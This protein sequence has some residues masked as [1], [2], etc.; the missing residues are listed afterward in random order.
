[1]EDKQHFEELATQDEAAKKLGISV[2]TLRKYSLII[3]DATNNRQHYIRTRRNSRLYSERNIVELKT[4]KKL[5][6]ENKLTLQDAA[7]QMFLISEKN[8]PKAGQ[9]ENLTHNGALIDAKQ[10]VNLLNMLQQTIVNQNKAI[11]DL[12]AQITRIEKQ[13]QQ[14]IDSSHQLPSKA[15]VA[16]EKTNEPNNTMQ[17]NGKSKSQSPDQNKSSEE[18]KAAKEAREEI[19]R[20]AR[21]NQQKRA[22]QNVHR[23]LAE[24]QIRQ[25]RH[26]WQK[27]FK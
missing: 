11:Q 26:W 4:L 17:L 7:K 5:A 24:M 16:K 23:T 27:I 13:N 8:D 2:A 25:K 14:L 6:K 20:K 19:L 9:L 22:Q 18:D 10:V 12:Q 15:T 3:E 1:M 21:E